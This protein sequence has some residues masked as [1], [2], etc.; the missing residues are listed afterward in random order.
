MTDFKR[1]LAAVLDADHQ[2]LAHPPGAPASEKAEGISAEQMKALTLL[3]PLVLA[4][5]GTAHL[6]LESTDGSPVQYQLKSDL[7]GNRRL[8][9]LDGSGTQQSQ[10][11]MGDD[12]DIQFTGETA[13]DENMAI[14]GGGFVSMAG[15]LILR[16]QTAEPTDPAEGELVSWLSDG[17][18]AG[19]TGDWMAKIQNGAVVKTITLIDFSAA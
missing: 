8:F 18:G 1:D 7:A 3:L 12:G 5:A 19:D 4:T 2:F 9:A 17:T 15:G 11:N 16:Q 10:I 13:G 6:T 14:V